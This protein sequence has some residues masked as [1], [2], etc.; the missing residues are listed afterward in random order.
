MAYE[1]PPLT[2]GD[3]ATVAARVAAVLEDAWQ[4]LAAEQAAV[5]AAIG[6]NARSRMVAVRLAQFQAAIVDFQRRVD[7][8]ARAFVA[9]QLPHLYAEGALAAAEAVGG[10]FS[11]TLIHTEALQSLAFDSYADFLRSSGAEQRMAGAFY[12]AVREAARREVPLL[13]SGDT[14]AL[15][16]AKALADQLAAEHQLTTVVYRNGQWVPVQAWAE[17]VTLAKSAVAYN[18]GT[19]NRA[20][21]AGVRFMKVFDGAGCGWTSHQDPDK[22]TDTLCSV[23]DAAAWPMSHPRYLR[24]FGPR[25]DAGALSA[26]VDA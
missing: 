10:H 19:L 22:A 6:D 18:A 24:A 26:A 12:R 16:A 14:T 4:R 17:S 7:T 21:E 25:P 15:Q 2:P 11:W 5:I 3:A 1:F 23:E 9:R 8:E 20:R 13:A